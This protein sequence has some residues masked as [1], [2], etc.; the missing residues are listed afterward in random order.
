MLNAHV[1]RDALLLNRARS[2]AIRVLDNAEHRRRG[3]SCGDEGD[4]P[5]I[6]DTPPQRV[7]VR[8]VGDRREIADAFDG[9][10]ARLLA[11]QPVV[12]AGRA[13]VVEVCSHL[14]D[15]PTSF[16]CRLGAVAPQPELELGQVLVDRVRH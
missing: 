10:A 7:R 16:A 12:D 1:N 4:S 13:H 14:L 5:S 2:L 3:G 15:E 11:G 9:R 8:G 6:A